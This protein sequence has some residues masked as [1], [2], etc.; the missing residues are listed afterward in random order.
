MK[1][2]RAR[3]GDRDAAAFVGARRAEGVLDEDI[4]WYWDTT[5]LER[6]VIDKFSEQSRLA[7][8]LEYLDRGQSPEQ[9]APLIR[10]AQAI[11]GAL[12]D[13]NEATQGNDRRLFPELQDRIDRFI[14]LRS[15][16]DDLRRKIERFS[17]V[18]AFVRSEMKAGRL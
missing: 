18:N 12:A 9:A 11:Y 17:S 7:L 10:K 14:E 6:R 4:R 2:P 13:D 15:S 3:A 8:F 16:S 5:E 1:S